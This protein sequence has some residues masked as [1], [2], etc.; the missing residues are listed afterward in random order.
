VKEDLKPWTVVASR[1]LLDA[2][3]YVKVR[4]ETIELPDGRRI[5]DFYQVDQQDFVCIFAEMEDGRVIA[6]EQ[7]RHGPRRVCMTFPGGHF[8]SP[9]EPPLDAARREL[10][11]ETGC[12]ATEWISLGAYVVNANAGDGVSHMFMARGCRQVAVPNSG[13]LEETR[14]LLLTRDEVFAAVARGDIALLTQM[15]L[16][17]MVASPGILGALA[18]R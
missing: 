5:D 4:V 8:A 14:I 11:E 17:A 9:G 2:S 6:M 7:Y 1:D 13:D 15:A 12:E 18:G 3:P 16:L 10:M